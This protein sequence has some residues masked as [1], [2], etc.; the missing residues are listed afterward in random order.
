MI[1]LMITDSEFHSTI[2]YQ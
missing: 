1:L 2:L